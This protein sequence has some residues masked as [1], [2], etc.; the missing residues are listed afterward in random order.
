MFA[1]AGVEPPQTY[2]EVIEVGKKIVEKLGEGSAIAMAG[3]NAWDL[4]HNWAI[5]LWA[6]GGSLLNDDNTKAVFNDAAGV[7]GMK[8]YVKLLQEGLASKACA[9]Y[10]QPQA[11]AAFINGNVAMCFMGPWNISGIEHDNPALNYGI[12][13]PPAGPK[14]RAAFSG[15]SNFAILKE[16]SKQGEAKAWIKFLLQHDVMIDYTKNLT[17]MLPSTVDGFDDPYYE[18]GMWKTFKTTLGYATAYPPLGVWG[19]IERAVQDGFTNVLRDYV[20]GKYDE[21]T[22]QKY[23]DGAAKSIDA[24]LENE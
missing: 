20:D 10:N 15:G 6:N 24:A 3:T 12:V 16:S 19:D 11:D 8:W 7:D 4:I 13:E 5:V 17:H 21:N 2:D 1:K 23:L 9:E 22:A 18:S 14:G